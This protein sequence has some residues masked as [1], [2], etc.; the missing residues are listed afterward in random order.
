MTETPQNPVLSCY[1]KISKA[2]DETPALGFRWI[3]ALRT[4]FT[5]WSDRFDFAG[6][7]LPLA[8]LD[9]FHVYRLKTILGFHYGRVLTFS[10]LKTDYWQVGIPFWAKWPESLPFK[11]D[12]T[13]TRLRV[14]LFSVVLRVFLMALFVVFAWYQFR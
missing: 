2:K 8:E 13:S 12:E 5:I 4:R 1:T 6:K 11:A 14:S 10:H 7:S 3:K 9:D